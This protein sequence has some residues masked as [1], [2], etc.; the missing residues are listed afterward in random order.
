MFTIVA[1][2]TF[3]VN[4]KNLKLIKIKE[5]Q[6]KRS[7]TVLGEVLIIQ[8][9]TLGC[10]CSIEKPI[11][12]VSHSLASEVAQTIQREIPHIVERVSKITTEP[13]V[14]SVTKTC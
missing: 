11:I 9:L 13:R 2:K 12:Q 3:K 7:I 14:F 6:K 8:R 5:C 1:F 10:C 4:S